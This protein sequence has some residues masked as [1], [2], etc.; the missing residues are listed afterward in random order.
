MT[1]MEIDM[2]LGLALLRIQYAGVTEEKKVGGK[3]KR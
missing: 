1:Y 2:G 3:E